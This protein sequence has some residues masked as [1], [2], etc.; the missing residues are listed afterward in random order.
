MKLKNMMKT[1]FGRKAVWSL[2]AV[3]TLALAVSGCTKEDGD[4]A[5]DEE[6]QE[7]IVVSS[8]KELLDAIEPDAN[9]VIKKGTYNFTEDLDGIVG[10][11]YS[12]FNKKHKYVKIEDCYDGVQIVIE[13]VDGLTISGQDGK[14]IELQVEPR[15]ADVLTFRECSNVALNNLTIGHTKEQGSCEG[16]VLQFEDSEK[17]TLTDLDLYGCGT[18]GICSMGSEEIT[19]SDSIIRDCS[20]G[21]L[22]MRNS[23]ASFKSCEFTGCEGFNLIEVS[24]SDLTFS[25]CT[26]ED[27]AGSGEFITYYNNGK[28][29]VAFKAC[30]FG[31]SESLCIANETDSYGGSVSFDSKCTFADVSASS[32]TGVTSVTIDGPIDTAGEILESIKPYADVSIEPG[33]YNLTEFIETV[34]VQ[35]W[36]DTHEYVKINPVYDGYSVD[37]VSIPELSLHSSTYDK[38]D[39]EIVV[40]PRYAEVFDFENV[41]DV[42]ISGIT[43]GHTD[44]GECSGD[45]LGFSNCYGITLVDL[46]LYGCGVSGIEAYYSGDMYVYL[47]IIRD[48][49]G[50][51]FEICY[52]TGPIVFMDCDLT[53]SAYAGYITPSRYIVE[54]ARCYFGEKES[55][56]YYNHFAK[57]MDCTF[58]GDAPYAYD[59]PEN[60]M[61]DHE[62]IDGLV[63]LTYTEVCDSYAYNDDMFY[64]AFEVITQNGNSILLPHYDDYNEIDALYMVLGIFN[65]G[66][67][68]VNDSS[69]LGTVPFVWEVAD[70]DSCIIIKDDPSS[71]SATL[72]VDE[73]YIHYYTDSYGDKLYIEFQLANLKFWLVNM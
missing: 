22:D 47:T 28:N 58:E 38:E 70:D 37:I 6:E 44:A 30:T 4:V 64:E 34:D 25:K 18:Y 10:D 65:D 66:T 73:A 7:A 72:G 40:E 11:D 26:F 32:S 9:I 45:V 15:Y 46:D 16:E 19:M 62:G 8:T 33:Y 56:I 12:K 71:D 57:L 43:M 59:R 53:G 60:Y 52:A 17:I 29:S 1:R 5:P 61:G 50:E 24:S 31:E 63:P 23:D 13:G 14:D 55:S 48:C 3:L 2:A 42:I 51:S 69:A 54:F 35:G 68:F 21:I 39:V 36:N 67:G 41:T 27:N 20:Y 49:S